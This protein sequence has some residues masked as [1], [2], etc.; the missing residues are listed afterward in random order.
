[1]NIAKHLMILAISGGISI[2][3][4]QTVVKTDTLYSP[5]STMA[6]IP[7][8]KKFNPE[9]D[10]VKDLPIVRALDS[11]ANIKFFQDN[12][13][14]NDPQMT[15]YYNFPSNYVPV[16]PDSVYSERIAEMRRN[17]PIEYTYNRHVKDYINLYAVK[18]RALTQRLLGLSYVY[19]P[20]FEEFLDK[21]DLP[22]E[23]KYLA[24]IESALNPKAGSRAGAK[25]LWQFMYG[26]GKVYGLSSTSFIDDRFDPYLSTDAACRHLKDLYDLYEDWFLVLAAYNAGAGNVNKAIRRAGGTKNY[27]R[28][29]PYLPAETRGYVPAF[30]AA[31]Y[32]MQYSREHNL[33]PLHPGILYNGIDTVEVKQPVSFDQIS[34][35]IGIPKEDLQF[36]NPIYKLGVIP[37][38]GD[39]H[40][41][42]RLP[43]DLV[44]D[45]INNE[46]TIYNYTSSKGI[47]KESLH[48]EIQK[49]SEMIVHVVRK[50][51]TIGKIARK[52]KVSV[53]D[54][55]AWNNLKSNYLKPRRRLTIYPGTQ[56]SV[57]LQSSTASKRIKETNKKIPDKTDNSLFHVVKKGETLLKI[58][59]KYGCS[60]EDLKNW[61][62][63]KGNTIKINQ[64]LIVSRAKSSK[65]TT[66]VQEKSTKGKLKYYTVK[67]GDTLW[68]IAQQFD[69]V[70]VEDIKRLNN[71]K[72]NKIQKGQRLKIQLIN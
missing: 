69:G 9:M 5:D 54:I 25:G 14:D 16:F 34:E 22:L 52:Y 53:N 57:T 59:K 67:E 3:T 70:T 40:Y 26:T 43:R 17:S 63:L 20:L 71:L 10:L 1:M 56:S 33:Y 62:N 28:I 37:V 18:K 21:Y 48:E 35:V 45:F 24:V 13:F 8:R 64:R 66:S 11:L 2:G 39:R 55:K 41:Y 72:N 30:I 4:A 44:G 15:Q 23:L 49:I 27:W 31:S 65:D 7:V 58:S 38:K 29:W 36:L 47:S 6:Y 19:F 46:Y 42:I 12:F 60:I 32:V 68:E 61:N 50:G 51:E